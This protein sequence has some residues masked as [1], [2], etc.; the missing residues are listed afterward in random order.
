VT[1]RNEDG[2]ARTGQA[3]PERV[4]RFSDFQLLPGRRLLLGGNDPVALTPRALSVLIAL[5]ERHDRIVTKEEIYSAVWGDVVVEERNLTVQVSVLRKVL[6]DDIIATVPGRGYKFAAK[7]EAP[8]RGHA[9]P[10]RPPALPATNLPHRADTLI[11]RDADLAELSA[12]VAR[13]RLVTLTGPGGMGKTRLAIELGRSAVALFP[14]GAW[15]VDL[16]PLTDPLLVVNAT[17]AV[18]GLALDGA[19]ALAGAIGQRKLLLILDN[20]EYLIGAAAAMVASLL[21]R[22]AGVSV[23]VTSQETLGL[24]AEQI[25]KLDPLA[26]PPADAGEIAGF[27]AV[28]LFVQ[29][30]AAADRRFRLDAAN[31]DAVK[32]ICRRLDGMPLALEM[33]ASRLPLLGIDG[34]RAAL[35]ERLRLLGTRQRAGEPR[36][37][38]LRAMV[39]WSHGLLDPVEQLLFRH[40]AVFPGS[41]SLDAVVAVAGA[42]I[43]RWE[44]ADRLGRLIDKSM[45]TI[46]AGETPRYRL[47]ETLRLHAAEKLAAAGESEAI[48]ERHARFFA[49]LF[50]QALGAWERMPGAEWSEIYWP[51]IG[52]VRAALDWTL[53]APE[54]AGLAIA[55]AGAIGCLCH[56]LDLFTEGRHYVDRAVALLDAGTPPAAAARLLR[57]AG[58]ARSYSDSQQALASLEAAASLYRQLGD[59]ANLGSVLASIGLAY[60]FRGR[61]VEAKAALLEASVLLAAGD[62]QK[63]RCRVLENLGTVADL[64]HETANARSWYARALDGARALRDIMRENTLLI[65]LAELEFRLGSIDEAVALGRRAVSGQRSIGRRAYLG[66]ALSNLAAYLIERGDVAEAKACAAEALAVL[67]HERRY[68]VRQCLQRWA[69][70]GALDGR[71]EAAALLIGFVDAGYRRD[72]QIRQPTEQ[73]VHDRLST[74]LAAALPAAELQAL[75]ARSEQWS[76]AQAVDFTL[77]RLV[78]A[79]SEPKD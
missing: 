2:A 23:L 18:L 44:M 31:A 65:S 36:H 39:E 79:D 26:L 77:V 41:F 14:D 78:A 22:A 37:G 76:A 74:A 21:D 61:Y 48:A 73:R 66:L 28:D 52:N 50:E 34:L 71:Y 10:A 64:T 57:G 75:A 54:R 72:G 49:D 25:Y 67:R 12:R 4:Y 58:I 13:H 38:T 9:A 8:A 63:S 43:D 45:V 62:H 29:R 47:L 60:G 40:L 42:E 70:I 11:G 46:E 3:S 16:A 59:D 53:A 56:A 32:D 5:V 35:G 68:F 51:E 19:D 24:A 30:A 7:L 33:A 69:L 15:L 6:G 20:C 27:G 55:L 17:A 1:A